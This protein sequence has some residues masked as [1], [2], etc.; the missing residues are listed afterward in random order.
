MSRYGYPLEFEIMRVNCIYAYPKTIPS[1]DKGL[2]VYIFSTILSVV[3][4]TTMTQTTSPLG[5]FTICRHKILVHVVLRG[6]GMDTPL[7]EITSRGNIS[8]SYSAGPSRKGNSFRS[9]HHFW[10]FSSTREGGNP[11]C[12]SCLPLQNDS[13]NFLG[14]PMGNSGE[15][16]SW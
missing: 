3:I 13:K 15:K 11:A 6:R 9:S 16:Q 1:M 12:Q 14:N 2:Q 7:R 10:K 4:P 5:A 8:I